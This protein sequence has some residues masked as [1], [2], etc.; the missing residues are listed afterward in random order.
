MFSVQRQSDMFISVSFRDLLITTMPRLMLLT[1]LKL[2]SQNKLNL[3]SPTSLWISSSSSMSELLSA[4]R[5]ALPFISQSVSF[6]LVAFQ[7][8]VILF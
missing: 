5:N 4:M 2:L 3:H 8:V 7:I 6:L 1:Y